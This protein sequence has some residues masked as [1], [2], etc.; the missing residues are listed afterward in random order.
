VRPHGGQVPV[1]DLRGRRAGAQQLGVLQ[2]P[3]G[4][5]GVWMRRLARAV[6][7]LFALWIAVLILGGLGL[8]P[9]V[10]L[11]LTGVLRPATKPP[12]FASHNVR[13]HGLVSVMGA[14][15]VS[16]AAPSRLGLEV[17]SRPTS[18]EAGR[19]GVRQNGKVG[20][21]GSH[22]AGLAPPSTSVVVPRPDGPVSSSSG[23][24]VASPRPAPTAHRPAAPP[25][26]S[27]EAT[28]PG[29]SPEATSPG[30]SPEAT[31]PGSSGSAPG[32]TGAAPGS[33]HRPVRP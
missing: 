24:A 7:G 3:T 13:P 22:P 31:S 18:R 15:G 5:R 12:P 30:Q 32:H 10:G 19:A 2:D 11:P 14:R 4:Q 1:V 21:G 17:G 16:R 25:G 29:Q 8:V 6:S 33:L 26:Q 9:A 20:T 28:S 27:P 23:P